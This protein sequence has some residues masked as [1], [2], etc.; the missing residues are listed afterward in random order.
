MRPSSPSSCGPRPATSPGWVAGTAASR[1]PKPPGS[2][3]AAHRRPAS[4]SSGSSGADTASA[5][6]EPIVSV[7][8][9]I[10]FRHSAE[11]KPR[12]VLRHRL[13]V[14][15]PGPGVIPRAQPGSCH[16]ASRWP[17]P[18]S[19]STRLSPGPIH[20]FSTLK[21]VARGWRRN[22]R[23]TSPCPASSRPAAGRSLNHLDQ[24]TMLTSPGPEPWAAGSGQY[25]RGRGSW[26]RSAA[27]C[28]A[29]G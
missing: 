18:S 3:G 15:N 25:A 13:L 14:T 11:P 6:A 19:A 5:A 23:F 28:A 26:F 7:S 8:V 10:V 4:V 2:P 12:S 24:V 16:M 1:R 17:G 9:L 27:A 21:T 29:P 20:C 22:E